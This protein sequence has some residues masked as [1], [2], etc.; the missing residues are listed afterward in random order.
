MDTPIFKLTP[1]I[2]VGNS[3]GSVVGTG[4]TGALRPPSGEVDGGGVVGVGIGCVDGGV[5]T[6]GGDVGVSAGGGVVGGL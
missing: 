2:V 4:V 3:D 5:G 6:T 1:R